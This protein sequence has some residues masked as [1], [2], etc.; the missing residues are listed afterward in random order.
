MLLHRHNQKQSNSANNWKRWT[1]L[2]RKNQH[3]R[4][5]FVRDRF[6]RMIRKYTLYNSCLKQ[7]Y[8]FSKFKYLTKK[9]I[10][11]NYKKHVFRGRNNWERLTKKLIHKY[12]K[13]WGNVIHKAAHRVRELKMK[14][15][16]T[17]DE[18][19]LVIATKLKP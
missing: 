12:D 17:V 19:W 5:L 15:K 4:R 1:K 10:F 7:I 6:Q 2:L 16:L 8:A 18:R 9:L 3:N 14:N 11:A 13:K